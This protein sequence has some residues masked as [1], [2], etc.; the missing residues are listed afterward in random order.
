MTPST[1][2]KPMYDV[3][4]GQSS[5]QENAHP[6]GCVFSSFLHKL[7]I[8]HSSFLHKF[9]ILHSSFVHF[10]WR[11]FSFFLHISKI[12]RTFAPQ[13]AKM[14]KCKMR[15]CEN[16]KMRKCENDQMVNGK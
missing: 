8:L 14:R 10:F 13:S 2:A 7:S 3:R 5:I 12:L 6:Q 4:G 9:Y 16:A 11:F 1:T 15:K